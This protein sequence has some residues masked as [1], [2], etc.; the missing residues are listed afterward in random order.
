MQYIFHLGVHQTATPYLQSTLSKNLEQLRAQ[1]V[2]YVNEEMPMAITRQRRVIRRLCD[3][4][5]DVPN[6]D[7]LLGTNRQVAEAARAAGAKTVLI[8]G[9]HG[10]GPAMHEALAWGDAE[11]AFY[12][13]AHSCLRAVTVG[14]P[15]RR[16]KALVYSRN[17]ET[18]LLSLY[19]DALR[20]GQAYIDL[21]TFCQQVAFDSIDFEGLR[22]RL[23]ALDSRLSVT[24]RAHER[25]RLG[26]DTFLRTFLRDMGVDPK[27]FVLGRLP[28]DDTLDTAQVEA[29]RHIAMGSPSQRPQLVKQLRDQVLGHPANPTDRLVLPRW[30]SESLR[31][32]ENTEVAHFSRQM[33]GSI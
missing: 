29:L 6:T 23:S 12:P 17:P 10:L 19:S 25:I 24:M 30:V 27:D 2:F 16:T 3:P 14:L 21:D 4:N 22:T 20:Q 5:R 31:A 9:D 18:Y 8:S 28:A 13:R 11:P 26:T 32:V 33:S 15:M 7:A 1:R